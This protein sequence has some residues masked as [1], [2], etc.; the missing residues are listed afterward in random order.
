LPWVSGRLQP[1]ELH[2][3]DKGDA[4]RLARV[5]DLVVWATYMVVMT[6]PSFSKQ[7]WRKSIKSADAFA[8]K[9]G[10]PWYHAKDTRERREIKDVE[11]L[12]RG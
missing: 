2:A 7:D 11:E 3:L 10:C 12:K 4:D 6:I 8:R 9:Y 5:A 1:N